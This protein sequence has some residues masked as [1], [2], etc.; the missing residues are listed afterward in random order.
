MHIRT[1]A[2]VGRVGMVVGAA[3]LTTLGVVAAPSAAAPAQPRSPEVVV[4]GAGAAPAPD[5]RHDVLFVHGYQQF[6]NKD[7]NEWNNMKSYFRSK[8]WKNSRLH[9]WGYYVDN[10]NCDTNVRFT[11]NDSIVKISKALA[12]HIYTEYTA[13]GKSVSIV[14]HSMGGLVVRRAIMGPN[15]STVGY[16]GKKLNVRD[17]VTLSSP[18]NGS[19]WDCVENP[20]CSTQRNQMNPGS[21]F[22][23]WMWKMH[24]QGRDQGRYGTQYTAVGSDYDGVVS[25]ASALSI[26]AEIKVSYYRSNRLTHGDMWAIGKGR[27]YKYDY[28]KQYGDSLSWHTVKQGAGPIRMAYLGARYDNW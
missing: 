3:T 21:A 4:R 5:R 18:H 12:K 22:Q 23:R 17:V 1:S 27:T 14:A 20:I 24:K 9:T 6:N 26:G 25:N 13:K 7:C 19:Y 8:G 11:R 10:K 2:R 28:N 16:K 15:D